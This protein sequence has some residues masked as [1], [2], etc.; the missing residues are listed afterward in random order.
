MTTAVRLFILDHSNACRNQWICGRALQLG[1][2][3]RTERVKTVLWVSWALSFLSHFVRRSDRLP[4]FRTYGTRRR[5]DSIAT[6][7]LNLG[8]I[9]KVEEGYY[10]EPHWIGV[11]TRRGETNIFDA[12]WK[13]CWMNETTQDVVEVQLARDGQVCG[14]SPG[15]EAILPSYLFCPATQEAARESRLVWAR[16]DLDSRH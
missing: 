14:L 10:D 8:R 7:S 5:P 2:L 9:W 4:Q 12:T 15:R 3:A 13:H 11:W 6:G 1:S 16:S